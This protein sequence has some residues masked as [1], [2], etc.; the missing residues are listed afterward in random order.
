MT[1]GAGHESDLDIVAVATAKC[2]RFTD[3][4]DLLVENRLVLPLRDTVAVDNDIDGESPIVLSL[5][6]GHETTHGFKKRGVDVRLLV[7][8]RHVSGVLTGTAVKR[9]HN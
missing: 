1:F 5:E 3:F 7:L 6:S 2:D 4:G 8:R 9:G